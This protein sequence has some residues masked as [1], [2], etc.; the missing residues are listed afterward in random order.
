MQTIT[1]HE[2]SLAGLN[3]LIHI[4]TAVEELLA[5]RSWKKEAVTGCTTA[6]VQ[7]GNLSNCVV[8]DQG[9]QPAGASQNAAKLCSRG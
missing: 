5:P 2:H 1:S 7:L 8:E 3:L 9:L 6:L 4:E